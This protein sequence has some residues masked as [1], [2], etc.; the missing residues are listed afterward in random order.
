[1]FFEKKEALHT[2]LAKYRD[3]LET[4]SAVESAMTIQIMK[5]NTNILNNFNNVRN[6]SSYAHDNAILNKNESKLICSHVIALLKFIDDI[7][8]V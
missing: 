7:G 5:A 2:L 4:S 8:Y 1:M 3:H 6:D